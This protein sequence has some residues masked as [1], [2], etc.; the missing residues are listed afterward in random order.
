MTHDELKKRAAMLFPASNTQGASMRR[1]WVS[2]SWVLYASGKHRLAR[3]TAKMP[4]QEEINAA[5]SKVTALIGANESCS[6]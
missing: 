3:Q 6:I 1:Q 5:Y 4:T 2:K